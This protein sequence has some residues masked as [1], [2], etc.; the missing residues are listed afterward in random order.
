MALDDRATRATSFGSI[1]EEYDR[2][3]P[4]P[5]A[6]AVDWILPRSC[7]AVVDI[8]AGTGALTR[9]LVGRARRVIAVEPD[10]RMAEVLAARVPDA[11]VLSG[12][13]ERLPL[14]DG[15]CDAVVGS[16][17][18][19][20]VDE[21][22][23]SREAARVLRP[24]GLLGLL[25]NGPN[26]SE[27]WLADVLGQARR[28]EAAARREIGDDDDER[29][30]LRV[31]LPDDAPFADPETHIVR[32]SITVT[33]DELVGLAG[34]YSG[35][36]V[37]PEAEQARLRGTVAELVRMHPA[38]VGRDEIE[39]PMRCLCWRAVRLA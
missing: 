33:P 27:G 14:P 23:A 6:A 20:W 30:R 16:S 13:A 37:L 9:Q 24:G 38:L 39:L 11:T 5:P 12:S 10:A 32:W 15:D 18:W 7:D 21:V 35:F 34:T 25:W 1:A 29:R 2:F 8:G 28:L 19:H 4:G 26:R 17:M 3:R 22:R 31:T 36:I